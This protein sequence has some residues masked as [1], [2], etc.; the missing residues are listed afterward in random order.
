[1][2][3]SPSVCV[4]VMKQQ[5]G[6]QNLLRLDTGTRNTKGS[7]HILLNKLQM[8]SRLACGYLIHIVGHS[9]GADTCVVE[10]QHLSMCQWAR[11]K[12]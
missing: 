8:V 6:H 4:G 7:K 11:D 3:E 2:K 12:P 10:L 1:M 9:A 5:Q